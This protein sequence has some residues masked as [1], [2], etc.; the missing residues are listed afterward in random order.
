M[1]VPQP[2]GRSSGESAGRAPRT[3][4][5]EPQAAQDNQATAEPQ[6]STWPQVGQLACQPWEQNR[7]QTK[8]Q[9]ARAECWWSLGCQEGRGP[10][11][12]LTLAV[13]GGL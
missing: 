11:G 10:Q 1:A 13:S 12:S 2:L 9:N 3:G 4:Q 6:G 5:E 7:L 8:T